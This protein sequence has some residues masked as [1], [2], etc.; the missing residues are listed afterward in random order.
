M[1]LLRAAESSRWE[2]NPAG[3]SL[4]NRRRKAFSF[5]SPRLFGLG[6]EEFAADAAVDIFPGEVLRQRP[7]L[8][9]GLGIDPCPAKRLFPQVEAETV[10]P[11]VEAAH[12][13]EGRFAPPP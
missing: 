7:F 8:K 3:P 1:A 6:K 13:K 9:G 2:R 11:A 5:P 4:V 10:A 12:E